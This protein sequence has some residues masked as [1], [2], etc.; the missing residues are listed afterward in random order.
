MGACQ[1]ALII[2]TVGFVAMVFLNRSLYH[3]SPDPDEDEK[4]PVCRRPAHKCEC[5]TN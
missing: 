2:M 1:I 5:Y 3:D 4:C